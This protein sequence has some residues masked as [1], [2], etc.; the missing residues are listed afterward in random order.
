MKVFYRDGRMEISPEELVRYATMN[1]LDIVQGTFDHDIF[2]GERNCLVSAIKVGE[3]EVYFRLKGDEK[4]PKKCNIRRFLGDYGI[5]S[6]PLP[7][8]QTG[9]QGRDIYILHNPRIPIK[10]SGFLT[11]PAIEELEPFLKKVE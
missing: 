9:L 5:D 7:G 2:D 3:E 11:P 4:N 10:N 6:F 8:S 1:A